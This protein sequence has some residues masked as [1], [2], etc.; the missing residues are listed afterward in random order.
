MP[1]PFFFGADV[2]YVTTPI[3]YVNDE[4]HIGHAY[5]TVAADVLARYGRLLGK[6]VF[7]L[8][9]TDEHGQK[10]AQAASNLNLSPQQQA[11]T[12][13]VRF[14]Q[15]WAQ[16]NISHNDFIR[17][18]EARHKQVVQTVL[19]R[20]YE[21][22]EIYE[23]MYEGW[24]CLS[25]E[26]FW[27]EKELT[28]GNCPDCGKR[29]E[30]LSEKNYFFRMGKYR[31]ALLDY[32]TQHTDFIQPEHRR[33][34]VLGF[35]QRPLGD[36]CISRPQSRLSWGVPLPFDNDYVTYV[37]LDALVNYISVP[38]YT[39]DD[40][41][42]E[43]HWPAIHLVGKDIL[44]THAVYWP[45]ILMALKLPLP[46]TIF[47]HGWWTLD[48]AKMSKSRGNVVHPNKII[49]AVGVDAFR[50]FL[51]REVPFGQDGNFSHDALT[52]RY[53]GD[54]ANDLG[55]LVSRTISLIGQLRG[56]VIPKPYGVI[57][58]SEREI[59]AIANTLCDNI[60]D[61]LSTFRFD[62]ALAHIFKLVGRTN[63]YIE[64]TAPW[65]LAKNSSQSERLDTVL[66]HMAEAIR[67]IAFY[68]RPF[69]PGTAEEI[70]RQLGLPPSYS[71]AVVNDRPFW[72]G[73]L[74]GARVVKSG[75]LFPRLEKPAPPAT[76]ESSCP[77]P[78][79][80]MMASSPVDKPIVTIDDFK[81]LDL[82]VGLIVAAEKITGSKKLLKLSVDI[83]CERRQIVAGIGARYAPETLVGKQ[84]ILVANLE[85]V[86]IMGV[87]SQGMLLA[88]GGTEVLGVATFQE[89]MP[90]GTTIQ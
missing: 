36:L 72:G 7:L 12:L 54:L 38:G 39:V 79:G 46:K 5:T 29:V 47:A 1:S 78:Q 17:T 62:R 75:P 42:F 76:M 87:L 8:T 58:V 84:I 22:G 28:Q 4:P 59:V 24:Y 48:G 9:G 43:R 73:R 67:C 44:T 85:P 68:L 20:L 30:P 15:L 21:R 23:A 41:R 6:D 63:G 66:F 11:D 61:D 89:D 34:E 81:K 31:E 69:M 2:F 64:H 80:P 40:V 3:Y 83:G 90:A 35:L 88:A 70:E 82:R 13:V 57:D 37:W 65:A 74:V 25:D 86:T 10:V 26:R 55:N 27:T 51:L 14:Q 77:V 53:N 50:Y 18:T 16:L 60:R 52:M 71:K 33:N 45:T 56:G 49:N 19:T 32:I